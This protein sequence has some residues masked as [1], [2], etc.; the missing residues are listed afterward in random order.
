LAISLLPQRHDGIDPGGA[1]RRDVARQESQPTRAV[2]ELHQIAATRTERRLFAQVDFRD[3][4]VTGVT[5]SGRQTSHNVTSGQS[6]GRRTR[7][8]AVAQDYLRDGDFT[9]TIRRIGKTPWPL[10]RLACFSSTVKFRIVRHSVAI[11]QQ[12]NPHMGHKKTWREDEKRT[13]LSIAYTETWGLRRGCS[14]HR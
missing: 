13:P 1:A 3:R 7:R 4:R 14:N 12:S 2:E 11:Q 10:R 9:P 5:R 8:S 6:P